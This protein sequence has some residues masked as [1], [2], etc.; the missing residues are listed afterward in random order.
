MLCCHECILSDINKNKKSIPLH[1]FKNFTI[2]TISVLLLNQDYLRKGFFLVWKCLLVLSLIVEYKW[3]QTSHLQ[4]LSQS[5]HWSVLRKD[6]SNGSGSWFF[7]KKEKNI[8]GRRRFYI[9]LLG[10]YNKSYLYTAS[11]TSTNKAS[12]EWH[13]MQWTTTT[14]RG[15]KHMAL[16][17]I[18]NQVPF[19][20]LK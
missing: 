13:C 12:R 4:G 17:T 20:K 18:C 5:A 7:L 6:K 11:T 8:L 2:N 16:L 10:T 3:R 9:K 15:N 14:Y 19:L 1:S